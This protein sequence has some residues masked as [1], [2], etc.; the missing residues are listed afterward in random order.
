MSR[1]RQP[2]P[3]DL[4][5]QADAIL[6]KQ[7]RTLARQLEMMR[8]MEASTAALTKAHE[9]LIRPRN[10]P[11]YIKALEARETDRTII[12]NEVTTIHHIVE[13][14]RSR[15]MIAFA[16]DKNR[17]KVIE[18]IEAMGRHLEARVIRHE[19]PQDQTVAADY[20]QVKEP[21]HAFGREKR[22]LPRK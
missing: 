19:D 12:A 16:H 9:E 4:E 22:S 17:P 7:Q 11:A 2:S 8:E 5:A 20:T 10:D 21:R 1:K 14:G 13:H 6:A 18:T 3:A 15:A